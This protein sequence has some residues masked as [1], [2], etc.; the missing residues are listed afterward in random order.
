MIMN[1]L[2]H[3]SFTV[4]RIALGS[5]L[6]L[7]QK[8][9]SNETSRLVQSAH[10]FG[11]NLFDTADIYGGGEA[12]R[13]LGKSLKLLNRNSFFIATKCFFPIRETRG[14][15]GK[16]HLLSSVESSL[17]NLKV[18]FLDILQCHRFDPATPL[19]ETIEGMQTLIK[20]GK[21]RYWGV[22]RWEKPQLMTALMICAEHGFMPPI[23]NQYHYNIFSREIEQELLSFQQD[24]G[25]G[26]L[27]YS[28][29]AQGV[30]T[31]KYQGG[32]P[33]ASSRAAV[34]ELRKSMWDYTADKIRISKS[35]AKVANQIGITAA[36][37]ALAWCLRRKE[38]N[39]VI[40]GVTTEKQLKENVRATDVKISENL[41]HEIIAIA[42]GRRLS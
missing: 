37:L 14:G 28:P 22:C 27:C 39:S 9:D 3:S 13:A 8:L 21:I 15:L 40:V 24:V 11:I 35:I 10:G 16:G 12:E 30:L 7:G 26:M 32:T 20:Q 34:G 31:G 38:V 33:P 25:I 36:E 18:D 1:K 5:W 41:E 19:Y 29:L 17:K 23:S 6:T 4:S 2:G 42:T